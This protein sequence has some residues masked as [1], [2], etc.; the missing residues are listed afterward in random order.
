VPQMKQTFVAFNSDR[1]KSMNCLTC[2]GDGALQGKFTMP[3]PRLPKLPATPDGFQKLMAEKPAIVQF[4][5]TKV[6]PQM[7]HLL[8][9]PE[10]TPQT[11]TGFGCFQCHTK[12]AQ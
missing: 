5:A 2:H 12:E 7:A 4:M 8:G 9:M 1:Y 11:K 3:N 10:F 6:K